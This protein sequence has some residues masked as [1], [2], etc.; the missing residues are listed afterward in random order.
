MRVVIQRVKH[1][2]VIIDGKEKKHSGKGLMI[3]LG[4][5]NS[6]DISDVQWLVKKIL[7]LR[8]FNDKKGVMNY[9]LIDIRG[10]LM[11][12]SQ[13]TLMAKT[14]KG[15]RPSYIRAAIHEHA[16]PLN[17]SFIEYSQKFLTK[18]VVSG[19]FGSEMQIELINDGPVTIWID[20]KKRE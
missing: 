7:N 14:K 19:K 18:P 12:I 5:E 9:S 8:I 17:N 2:E 15:N 4:I 1:A 3:L 20:S 11:I 6:D 16:I 10:E 13:F